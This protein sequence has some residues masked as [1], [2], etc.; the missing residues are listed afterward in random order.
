MNQL[1]GW[2]FFLA[3]LGGLVCAQRFQ[4]PVIDGGDFPDPG[5]IFHEGAYY[6]VTTTNNDKVEKYPIH[7]STDLQ[8]WKLVGY[9]FNETNFP[10]W[11]RVND[12][13][14]APEIHRIGNRY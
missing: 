3:V 6:A 8:N 1:T 12:N 9:V 7:M 11:S 13:F 2:W 4:N 14:W 10:V 5:V